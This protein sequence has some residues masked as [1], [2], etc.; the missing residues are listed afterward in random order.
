MPT[1]DIPR[2]ILASSSRYRAELLAR[3]RLPF[4]VIAPHTD[5]TPLS[6]EAAADLALRLAHAKAAAVAA[7]Q[8]GAVVIGSD[9]VALCDDTLL[10]KPG[11]FARARAQLRHMSGRVT[12]FH[13]AVVVTD[14]VRTRSASV[15]TH[16]RMRQLDDA[17]IEAYLLA[18]TPYDTAGSAK[19]EGLGVALM[20]AIES[21]DPTALIGL[22]LIALSGI[23]AEFGLDPLR[24][25]A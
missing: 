13:T 21:Q 3:L 12:V 25:A 20:A 8:P 4:A 19:A 10:G 14:G 23:L 15:P 18:E 6:G 22:P 5:E 24:V 7:S 1:S 9:Q 16:C 2:L 17:A 11:D